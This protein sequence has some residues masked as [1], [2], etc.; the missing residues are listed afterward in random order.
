MNRRNITLSVGIG[1]AVLIL[2]LIL[3]I[4]L[5]FPLLRTMAM[6][7]QQV[8]QPAV[9]TVAGA[10]ELAPTLTPAAEGAVQPISATLAAPQ[11]PGLE[12]GSLSGLYEQLNPGVVSIQVYI[13]RETLSGAAAGSGFI[14]DNEG[15]IVTN[16]HVIA[17]ATHVTVVFFN[18]AEA[19]AKVVGADVESD[20]AVLKVDQL[21]Q[22][23]HLLPLADS[24]RV[25]VGEWVVAI[26]NPFELGG[27]MSV[28]IVSAVGRTIPTGST[29]FV[30]PQAIQTDAAI[31][32]GNSGG[33]LLNLQ[34][35]VIGVNA[36]ILSR[37][38]TPANAGVGFAIPSNVVRRIA[39]TLIKNGTYHWPWLGVQGGDVSLAV[40]EANHLEGQ[41]GAYIADVVPNGPAD[42]A[43][44]HGS[45]GT[46]QVN[47]L[48]VPVGG[49]VVIKADGQPVTDFASLL[50]R[51]SSK[52]PGDTMTLTILRNGKQQDVTITLEPRPENTQP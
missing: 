40:M 21:G 39:P 14:L 50:V 34:G 23:T 44:L 6:P 20:L 24:D 45:S 12:A 52:N 5:V 28:G 33:P 46:Q 37:S 41:R 1:C 8:S 48:E 3:G 49:D 47:E 9:P 18:G 13:Q 11:L 10:S 7:A 27:S 51:V 35:E 29:P 2:L 17:D 19:E 16:N 25:Q 31:N 26:G 42:K 32:P 22:G 38:S 15:H 36:Q 4:S 30:I 43:G